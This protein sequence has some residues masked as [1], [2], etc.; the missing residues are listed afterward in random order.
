ML[1]M[2]DGQIEVFAEQSGVSDAAT[3]LAEVAQ[4]NAWDFA[5]RPWIWPI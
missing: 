5:R 4:H 1:P 2:S 3:F